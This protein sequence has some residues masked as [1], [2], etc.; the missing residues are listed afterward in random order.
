MGRIVKNLQDGF[1]KYHGCGLYHRD[2]SNVLVTKWRGYSKPINACF[3]MKTEDVRKKVYTRRRE[4]TATI[5]N[6][7]LM[8]QYV[9][10]L[11][12]RGSF[13]STFY[14]TD[15]GTD[16]DTDTE[17]EYDSDD[18]RLVVDIENV[19]KAISNPVSKSF[20][21]LATKHTVN[22]INQTPDSNTDQVP[23]I[24]T[25]IDQTPGIKTNTDQTPDIK[26]EPLQTPDKK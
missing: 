22:L 11:A 19:V 2:G 7:E 12:R 13:T 8:Q 4:L 6:R 21:K 14:S 17:P 15:S 16:S 5:H 9:S 24:K 23:G 3:W 20:S 25:N 18:N 26:N 1:I 10:E